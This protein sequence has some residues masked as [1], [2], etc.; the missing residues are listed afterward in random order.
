VCLGPCPFLSDSLFGS[1]RLSAWARLDMMFDAQVRVQRLYEPA[2]FLVGRGMQHLPLMRIERCGRE[3]RRRDRQ[4]VSSEILEEAE[5]QGKRGD[6]PCGRRPQR[7]VHALRFALDGLQGLSDDR[8]CTTGAGARNEVDQLAP[9]HR[10]VVTVFGRLVE[11]G[12]QTIVE[13]HWLIFS[14]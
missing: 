13:A 12:Q 6:R 3:D 8:A 14:L 9:A 11:D 5:R 10:R 4:A 2:S 7:F 1:R